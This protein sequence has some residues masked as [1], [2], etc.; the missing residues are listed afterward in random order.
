VATDLQVGDDRSGF[1]R[2]AA[3]VALVLGLVGLVISGAGLAIA[4]LPRHFTAGQQQAI[5]DWEVNGR[6][7]NLPAGRIFP[8]AVGYTLPNT[9]MPSYP[10]L[11]LHAVRVEIAPQTGCS[12]GVSDGAAAEVLHREGCEA[13]LR[14]TY[15][16]QTMSFVMTVGVAVL[17]TP[18]AASAASEG[19]SVTQV[20]AVEDS[21]APQAGV[22]IVHFGGSDAGL[23][24]YSKQVSAT[25]ASGPYLVLYAAGYADGRPRVQLAHDSY[26]QAEITSLAQGVATSVA[27]TL[28]S[29]PAAPHCPG[30]PGC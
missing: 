29:T 14:A 1:R 17:P 21:G 22:R 10:P 16:D 30:S 12:A 7:R 11:E 3:L 26:S 25:L 15:V 9:V 8:D 27:N 6:W 24:D 19:L 23:Y 5:M 4:I 28:G 18:T 20:A 13:M 2:I